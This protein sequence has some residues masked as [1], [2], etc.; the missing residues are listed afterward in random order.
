MGG[1]KKD[2]KE[3]PTVKLDA[4][5][6]ADSIDWRAKGAVTPVGN[7]LVCMSGWA[8]AAIGVME[9]ANFIKNGK[10]IK[11]SEQEAIDCGGTD[12]CHGGRMSD[13]FD[14]AE[15]EDIE[16]EADYPYT[17]FADSCWDKDGA[18]GVSSIT[19]VKKNSVDQMKAALN[20]GPVA[21]SIESTQYPFMHYMG[22]VINDE[23]CGVTQDH[24]VLVVGYGID[25][26][27][28]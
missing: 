7:Q 12:G 22:G 21:T 8:F 19:Q 13:L 9:S 27:S 10:L 15:S 4:S 18:V 20:K 16:T 17:G 3:Y 11:L 24:G 23:T 5:A 26:E 25:A 1:L 6:N 14:F 2:N 28:S